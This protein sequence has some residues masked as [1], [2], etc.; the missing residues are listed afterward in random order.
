MISVKNKEPQI[1]YGSKPIKEV[2]KGSTK[3]Y[4]SVD[5]QSI[6]DSMILWYDIKKQGATNESMATTPTLIDHSGNGHDATCY[7]FAWS[8]MS[9]IGGYSF[10]TVGVF[11]LASYVE[12]D[13]I[14]TSNK[15]EIQITENNSEQ[16]IMLPFYFYPSD[17]T[18]KGKIRI[19][20]ISGKYR[21]EVIIY[22]DGIWS[23]ALEESKEDSLHSV[24][25]DGEYTFISEEEFDGFTSGQIKIYNLEGANSF[26]N[27][28]FESLPLYP[29]ALVSDGVD[30]Y[31]QVT[32]LPILTKERGY[33]VVAKRKIWYNVRNAFVSKCTH[34]LSAAEGGVNGAFNI[35]ANASSIVY[36][37]GK[38]NN[39]VP[40]MNEDVIYQTSKLCN[41]TIISIGDKEDTDQMAFFS[42][43]SGTTWYTKA[44]LY[45]FLLFDR[46]L[47][48]QEIEWVKTNLIEGNDD[49]LYK[50][51]QTL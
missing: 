42:I 46:D 41:G 9:G 35:Q 36:N 43:N 18:A 50:K 5:V 31:A 37:F 11:K 45:S 21:V 49:V 10:D 34:W 19:S 7:N 14:H 28:I 22:K 25:D 6:M 4:P 1:Y 17:I 40:G 2:Y 15:A 44:A 26:E 27:I 51:Q 13:I 38:S 29:N 30:D 39:N 12:G 23:A 33:T 47:T 16:S 32:G 20:G 24:Y 48:K 3:I 8:L